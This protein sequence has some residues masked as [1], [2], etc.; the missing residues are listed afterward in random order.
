MVL[1][2]SQFRTLRAAMDRVIPVDDFPGAWDA[3]CGDF[4]TRLLEEDLAD[5]NL[6]RQGL[7]ALDAESQAH[8][9]TDFAD[10]APEEQDE[11]L[12][13]VEVGSVGATWPVLPGL[14]F[15]TLVQHVME[16]YYGNPQNGGNRD[17]ASWQMIGF[18]VSG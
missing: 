11:L 4:V 13:G 1:S 16:G 2:Q 9:L 17:E 5:P 7:D 12:A 3:G 14:F 6:Y 15:R 18:E 8:F 10:L